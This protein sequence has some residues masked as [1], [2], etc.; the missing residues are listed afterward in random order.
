M[1]ITRKSFGQQLERA[2]RRSGF[3]PRQVAAFLAIPVA[4][5]S[6]IERGHRVLDLPS[7]HKLAD[8]YGV[9]LSSLYE[10]AEQKPEFPKALWK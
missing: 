3:S 9:D 1:A 5:L 2:R 6:S 4:Q 7:A 10:H 8:L